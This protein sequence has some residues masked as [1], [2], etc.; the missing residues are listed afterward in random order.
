MTATAGQLALL[1]ALLATINAEVNAIPY[2]ATGSDSTQDNWID[3]PVPGQVWQCR[4]YAIAKAKLLREQ[5]WSIEEMGV[6]LCMTEVFA[7]PS[8]PKG[9]PPARYYHAVQYARAGG[10]VYILDNR[11]VPN[12]VPLWRPYPLD[13]QWVHQEMVA[14]GQMSWRDASG[15][16]V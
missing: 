2:A 11:I 16:L 9:T 14:N 8:M 5:G 7:D 13:Y 15:G 1:V 3:N 6:V 12:A 10:A 4:D